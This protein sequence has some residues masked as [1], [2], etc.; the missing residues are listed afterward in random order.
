MTDAET[1]WLDLDQ[2]ADRL[3][4]TKSTIQ[5][6]IVRWRKAAPLTHKPDPDDGRKTL[7]ADDDNLA[8]FAARKG[9]RLR[10]LP[11]DAPAEYIGGDS[12]PAAHTAQ[13]TLAPVEAEPQMPLVSRRMPVASG[14]SVTLSVDGFEA[15]ADV[16]RKCKT[17]V[18]L[19]AGTPLCRLTPDEA[20]ALCLLLVDSLH[21]LAD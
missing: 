4:Y 14:R 13:P 12:A 16:D 19:R 15:I 2:L 7:Y 8:L 5:T 11:E 10:P 6:S 17:V 21:H 3:G 18:V 1:R 9:L 20:R